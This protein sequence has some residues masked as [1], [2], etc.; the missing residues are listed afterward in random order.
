M[1]FYFSSRG[2][3]GSFLLVRRADVV[4]DVN[5]NVAHTEDDV[6]GG[7]VA[8]IF[9]IFKGPMGLFLSVIGTTHKVMHGNDDVTRLSTINDRNVPKI[10][11]GETTKK[12]RLRYECPDVIHYKLQAIKILDLGN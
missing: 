5:N 8:L 4:D 3:H 11:R 1:A 6:G 2:P 9:S 10:K 7:H 12:R